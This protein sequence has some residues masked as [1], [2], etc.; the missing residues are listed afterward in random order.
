MIATLIIILAVLLLLLV[1]TFLALMPRTT[2]QEQCRPFL[3]LNYAHRGLFSPENKI[4]ENSM[5][6]FH[7]ALAKGFAIELDVQLTKD[8]QAVIFHDDSLERMCGVDAL[9]RNKTYEELQKLTLADT[10]YH[11]P[12]LSDVL[13][14]VNGQVPLLVELKSYGR[15]TMVSVVTNELLRHYKGPFCIQSFS[16]FVLKWFKEHHPDILRG[17]LSKHFPPEPGK[18]PIL[19]FMAKNLLCNFYCK[20]DFISYK[21]IQADKNLSINIIRKLWKTPIFVW[22]IRSAEALD[23]CQQRYDGIIFDSFT[24]PNTKY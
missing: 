17:S 21:Y 10:D 9:L 8:K 11:I 23:H 2:H 7:H 14:M 22:T 6:A 13:T 20:P 15:N 4:P 16:P 3:H 18:P 1:L 24:P 19:L 12:L 5:A